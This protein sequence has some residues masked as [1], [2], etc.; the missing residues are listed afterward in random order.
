MR[1]PN[2]GSNI[3]STTEQTTP[4]FGHL[5]KERNLLTF[6]LTRCYVF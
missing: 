2:L 6:V 1:S 5:S 3:D 4:A